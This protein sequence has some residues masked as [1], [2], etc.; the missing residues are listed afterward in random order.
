MGGMH[1]GVV[2][3]GIWKKAKNIVWEKLSVVP[4]QMSPARR[5]IIKLDFTNRILCNKN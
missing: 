5:T 3:L 2:L 1:E 4:L